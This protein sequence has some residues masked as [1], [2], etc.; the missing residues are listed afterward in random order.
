[1]N[2]QVVSGGCAASMLALSASAAHGQEDNQFL[3]DCVAHMY[4]LADQADRD[5]AEFGEEQHIAASQQFNALGRSFSQL[6]AERDQC[7]TPHD[8]MIAEVE[9]T[10]LSL[11]Q[12]SEARIA[13]GATVSEAYQVI[14]NQALQCTEQVG[15]D[16]I[17]EAYEARQANGPMCAPEAAPATEAQSF[18]P[19]LVTCLARTYIALDQTERDI[20][21]AS[22]SRTAEFAALLTSN[23][24]AIS[25]MVAE[26]S[27]CSGSVEDLITIV[28]D[29]QAW[30]IDVFQTDLAAS[31]DAAATY[32][33]VI[34]TPLRACHQAIGQ[35][36]IDAANA[37]R[38]AN[39][40]ACG[41]GL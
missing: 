40:Y 39:G 12:E 14:W 21:T 16:A 1:M 15:N 7:Q 26:Q 30:I 35:E 18:D 9:A 5:V 28:G 10:R 2:A 37:D 17:A 3:I 29:A 8:A 11:A 38:L 36:R 41:W 27:N 6:L 23:A 32:S 19:E 33:D 31:G 20:P 34:L 4:Y 22:D 24:S 13:D 25:H